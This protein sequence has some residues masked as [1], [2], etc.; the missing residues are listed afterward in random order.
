MNLTLTFQQNPSLFIAVA[1]VAG[2]IVGSFLNVVIHRLPQ[3][4]ARQWQ[5]QC[6]ELAGAAAE[7]P[8]PPPFNLIVPRSRCPHC[9]HAI[10]APENIP[11]LS[12]LWLRGRCSACKQPIGWRY[13]VVEGLT[14]ALTAVAAW[15]FGFS[16]PALAA[17][18]FG[19][20]LIAL[21]FIDLDHQLLPDAITLPLL[22]AGLLLNLAGLVAPAG[23]AVI[24]AAAGY[25]SLWLLFH[26]YRLLTG[27]EGMGHGD[28]KLF[29]A[30]GAWLGWQLLPLVI[31]LASLVGAVVG[32]A[33]ILTGGRDRHVPIPFGPFLCAA[34][35]TGL[36][37][38][39]PLTRWYL[40]F[41]RLA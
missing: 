2:L 20:A 38:G 19:W 30:L 7:E 37:W 29:A 24:G 17:I 31:L 22:W 18:A 25:L 16:A 23:S 26:G 1:G 11:L 12:F 9:G 13:P 4:L 14:A 34:G 10:T 40:Q 21:T 27:K 41:A 3:M 6:R 33:F 32:L 5:A 39:E 28:F 35:W 8:P 36:M 15:H